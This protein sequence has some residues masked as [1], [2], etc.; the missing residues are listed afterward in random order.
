MNRSSVVLLALSL[1]LI[2]GQSDTFSYA[3]NGADWPGNCAAGVNESPIDIPDVS[4]IDS[5][6]P[7]F[8]PMLFVW[9]ELT[10]Y[11]IVDVG[12]QYSVIG[13]YGTFHAGGNLTY[14]SGLYHFHAP[15]EHYLHGKQYPLEMHL[16]YVHPSGFAF[17]FIVITVFFE[18][19]D[20]NAAL[21]GLLS[22]SPT[23][24]NVS[25]IFGGATQVTNYYHYQGTGTTPPC[26][27]NTPW[28]IYGHVLQA[29]ATQLDFFQ[30]RWQNNVT[31]AGG[32]GNNRSLQSLGNRTV[33]HYD[34]SAL[35]LTILAATITL[36][37]W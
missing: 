17:G 8:T 29:S 33:I 32:K 15:S 12:H 4:S 22:P 5:S 21:A 9:K 35:T 34:D 19:G 24:I 36:L 28:Y 18:Q 37:S 27:A 31:F 1:V 11:S 26:Q 13:D 10:G 7:T 20:E 30:R 14:T 6:D 25:A 3:T 16:G 23:A 2:H